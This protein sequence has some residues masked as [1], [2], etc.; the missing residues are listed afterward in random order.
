[1]RCE[2]EHIRL[3]VAYCRHGQIPEKMKFHIVAPLCCQF[4]DREKQIGDR[5]RYLSSTSP[6]IASAH[7]LQ[8]NQTQTYTM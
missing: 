2:T 3:T 4:V 1:M 6:T 7:T 8:I 5:A